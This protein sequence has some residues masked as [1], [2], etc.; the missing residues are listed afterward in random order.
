MQNK[1]LKTIALICIVILGFSAHVSAQQT[2]TLTGTV[3]GENNETMP[4]AAI[5]VKGTT[6]GTTADADGKFT[7]KVPS[8]AK[9]LTVSFIGMQPQEVSIG[10][11]NQINVTL[12]KSTTSLDEVVVVGYGVQKKKLVTGATVQ[13]KGDAI[14][15]L[16]TTSPLT[17]LQSQTPGVIIIKKSGEPG[18]GFKVNIRGVGTTGNSQP[19][20]IVD[21]VSRGNIDYLNPSDIESI[22]VLKD[23][24]SAAIYGSRASN[25]VILVT[26][27]QG[28]AGKAVI[29]LDS[30]YGVQNP[31]KILPLLNAKEYAM[32]M[33]EANVNSG[34][35]PY[36]F[37]KILGADSWASIQNGTWNGTNWLK[38]M[39]NRNAPIQSHALNITGGGPLSVYSIGLSYTS[40]DGIF[41]KPVQSN[42]DRYTV[43][44]NTEH[45]V[46]KKNDLDIIKV[47]ENISFTNTQNHGIGTGN[48]YWNDIS[49]AVKIPPFL[50]LW[51][52]DANGNDI[53]G[54]YH[55]AIPWNTNNINP[56]GAMVY[57]R[58][59]NQSKNYNL[60]SN[61][62]VVIQPLKGL[63]FRSS[64]GINYSSNTYR[65]FTP[66]YNLGAISQSTYNSVSQNMSMGMGWSFENTLN[67]DFKI[68]NHNISALVGTSA[69][70]G[71]LGEGLSV[72]SRNSVFDDFRHA[73]IDNANSSVNSTIGGGPWDKYGLESYFGRVNYDYKE[74]YMMTL[75]MRADASSNFA[76][77]HRWGYFPSVSG[78]WVLTNED[79]MKSGS[80]KIDFLKLRASWGQNG[81]QSIPGFQYISLIEF[82]KTATPA[83]YYFD[84]TKTLPS[85][86]AYPGN[87]PTPDLSWETSEQL[88]LGIDA[89]FFANKLT[90]AL[91]YYNKKTKDWLVAAPVLGS[92]G[93][94]NKPYIN[95]GDI[96]N[97]GV[98]I[99][100][101]WN[102]NVGEFKYGVN[103]NLGYNKNK[104]TRIDNGQGIINAD[105]VKLWGNGPYIARAQVGYPIGYFW[106]Y[107]TAGIFQNIAQVQ[108]YKNSKGEAIMPTAQPGDV[109]FVDKNDDGIID[110]KDKVM[111]GDPNP[112]FLYS[113][114]MNCEYKGF[115]FAV[116]TNGV[117]GNQIARSWHDAGDGATQNFTTA[118]L[119]R[120]HGEGTSNTIPRVL[121]GSSIN[122]Q[123]TSDLDIENG[124]YL[125]I[126]NVT[127]GYDF[128]KL[129]KSLPFQQLRFYLTVQNLYTFT[130]YSGMDPEIGT[131]TDDSGAGW[132]NGVDLGF[133][134][135][136]RTVMFGAS[137]KF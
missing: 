130:K 110:D 123:Y 13:I 50:P 16:N 65:A 119:G 66:I 94:N 87:L 82:N 43:R 48:M 118:I 54:T 76:E 85:L 24:A 23:A 12:L 127:L 91:D 128:K 57:Q 73:Y 56:I 7:L 101:N 97:Q 47:G 2:K 90:L 114:N 51:E 9:S 5:M 62:Y 113:F 115:D 134:P 84:P 25:G 86:G 69:E 32:I 105:N 131:S 136:P 83:N 75:V 81:N 122:Q 137:I 28:K 77:G 74:T 19:L 3:Y 49:N 111:I 59:Y 60:N 79:F 103:A 98:E 96:T 53:V 40:Q 64:F 22:D 126:N 6:I 135:N 14:Q 121:N 36:D 133:Y 55:K 99:A 38:E 21:G 80:S 93:V 39:E 107:N 58:G 104:V 4:G 89:R 116:T 124:D 45:L 29:S 1:L 92:W 78:G 68:K 70:R 95:G 20:Y 61:A 117:V 52:K 132:V 8:T 31:Y 72:G 125:R 11:S 100:L 26:T 15:K 35:K 129:F 17:A 106:G 30:Y 42:Y 120:W 18:G 88:D 71:G 109:I 33:N 27:K 102:S 46:Y 63:K 108:G 112:D 37:A 67:Y 44:V 41:G 10:T 34:L